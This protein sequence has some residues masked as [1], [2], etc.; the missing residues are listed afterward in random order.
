MKNTCNKYSLLTQLSLVICLAVFA[1]FSISGLIVYSEQRDEIISS[2]ESNAR[3]SA[4]RLIDTLSPFMTAYSI[5]EYDNLVKTEA[6]LNRHL[7]II[8]YDEL[9]GRVIGEPSFASGYI[10]DKNGNFKPY[11]QSLPSHNSRLESAAFSLSVPINSTTGEPIGTLAIYTSSSVLQGAL[12]KK[13]AQTVTYSV[14]SATL[15]IAFLLFFTKRFFFNPLTQI[16]SAIKKTDSC[17]LPTTTIPDFGSQELATLG[18]SMNRMISL[19]RN[20]NQSLIREHS[21]LQNV[22]EGTRTGTWEFNTRTNVISYNGTWQLILG[23]NLRSLNQQP[24]LDWRQFIHPEDKELADSHLAKLF[25]QDVDYFDCEIR[26]QNSKEQWVHV[27]ARGSV[28]EWDEN[29]RPLTVLG[30]LQDISLHKKAE[31]DQR[32]AAKVFTH[33]REGIIITD[34]DK[35]IVDVNDA[36]CRITGYTA[37][38]AKGRNPSFLQSG[39][40]DETFY[41]KMWLSLDKQGHWTGEIWNRRKN[42]DLY[43][44]LLTISTVTDDQGA[45]QNYVAVFSDITTYKEHES[46]LEKIAHFD[47]LTGLPNRLLLNDRLKSAMKQSIR[48]KQFVAVI[49]LDL[50]GFK[51]VNDTYGHDC[52]DMLLKQIA[53]R[54]KKALRSCDTIARIGGDEFVAVLTDLESPNSCSPL[55]PRLLE[56]TSTPIDING[57]KLQISGSMGVTTY[58]QPEKVDSD[59]L[60]RQADY[61]MYQAKLKGKNRYHFFDAEL[62]QSL[63]RKNKQLEEVGNAIHSNQLFLRYQPKVNLRTGEVIG[64]EALVRW[65]HP[66]KGE[67]TPVAFIPQ[68]ENNSRIIELGE[69]VLETAASQ[70]VSWKAQGLETTISINIAPHHLLQPD[71]IHK[72]RLL[73]ARYPTIR[74]GQLELEILET[75]AFEDIDAV[76]DVISQCQ[77][78]GVSFA[79]DD[80]GT[81][82]ASLTYLKNLPAQTLKIDQSFIH[83]L[84]VEAD[85]LVIL[86]G[87]I[88][89]AN[90]FNRHVVAEGIET[91]EQARMLLWLGCELGQG[92]GISVPLRDWEIPHWIEGW[93]PDP[94]WYGLPTFSENLYPFIK[95][96]SENRSRIERLKQFLLTSESLEG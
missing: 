95:T 59:K 65:A 62:E 45:P 12:S 2:M 84:L 7:A 92:Y 22:I 66:N 1:T 60:L 6:R 21:R 18:Y 40:Q 24:G 52:G 54:M 56:A 90:T 11:D 35:I 51:M 71:F 3:E 49:F 63:K 74:S 64:V 80:F 9:M 17:G 96:V 37:D 14:F 88:S 31:D 68:I 39:Q 5:H 19:I 81:G 43:P 73:L 36:F 57:S 32:L 75:S 50:D 30:T 44:E 53:S 28:M 15:L 70:L 33:A 25:N 61:A 42:G 85:N 76:S 89:L 77:E 16:T 48:H 86:E 23:W 41:R 8:V 91:A 47:P 4:S 72:L 79:I 58:P 67:L 78:L 29:N 55:L 27:L 46:E 82:Y 26:V 83:D 34:S 69:W 10:H 20:S 93:H 13:L 87:V 94:S 38:E